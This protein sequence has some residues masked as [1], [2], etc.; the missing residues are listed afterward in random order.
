[1]YPLEAL[2][3]DVYARDGE[4]LAELAREDPVAAGTIEEG[5][6]APN[7]AWPSVLSP[8]EQL[9]VVEGFVGGYYIQLH[10]LGRA[11]LADFLIPG[12]GGA[13]SLRSRSSRTTWLE[14][15]WWAKP[16][17]MRATGSRLERDVRDRFGLRVPNVHFN[18]HQNYLAMR[19]HP[20]A[21]G[22]SV[23]DAAMRRARSGSAPYP[24][25]HNLG[26]AR[27]SAR[28]EDGIGSEFGRAPDVPNLFVSD[29]SVMNTEAGSGRGADGSRAG[30]APG[31]P[32]R[33]AA[34]SG[35]VSSATDRSAGPTVFLC[36]TEET[37][38]LASSTI[39]CC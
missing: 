26:T 37:V 3:G 9:E 19:E 12:P 13:T 20:Y 2:P 29:G 7:D 18:D 28:P 16:C 21:A 17:R 36:L 30:A 24:T 6:P 1:M 22:G 11:S 35:T 27:M 39:G 15:G 33:G 23:C 25:R 4:K 34:E 8:G 31:R 38:M 32:H 14:C 5:A 10:S